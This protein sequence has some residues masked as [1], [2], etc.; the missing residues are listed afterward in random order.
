MAKKHLKKCSNSLGTREIQI[1][2]NQRFHLTHIGIAMI[3]NSRDSTYWWGCGVKGTLLHCWWEYKL[4][5]PLWK[6]TWQFLRK[7]DSSTSRL[8]YSI[9]GH[10]PKRCSSIPERHLLNYVHSSFIGNSLLAWVP[11]AF[12]GDLWLGLGLGFQWREV[13]AGR[14]GKLLPHFCC[15]GWLH[16]H[17]YLAFHL[18]HPALSWVRLGQWEVN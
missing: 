2:T 13:S 9:P 18:W 16:L 15:S 10:I 5:Q 11:V 17:L 4:R 3:K 8:S 1:K 12:H 6:S 7:Q 14:E